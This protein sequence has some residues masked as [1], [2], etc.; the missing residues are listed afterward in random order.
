MSSSALKS[1]PLVEKMEEFM[2][3]NRPFYSF[4]FFPPKTQDGVANLFSRIER[5]SM[6]EPMFMDITWGAGGSTAQLTMD[7]SVNAQQ[8]CSTDVMMHLTCTEMTKEVVKDT[9]VKAKENGVRNILALRGDPPRGAE[10]WQ[11]CEGGFSHAVDLVRFI[12]QE[13]GDHFGIAVAGYP[14]G[15]IGAT[16]IDDDI[17]F[18]KEKVEAGADLVITQLFYDVDVFLEW[19]AKCRKAGITCPII[20]GIMPI[21]NYNGFKRMTSFCKTAVPQEIIE[22]LEPIK[23]D[24]ARVKAYG[25]DL[26]S[27]MCQKLLDNGVPGLHF[28]TL[29]LERSVTRIL[30]Q[31][32]FVTT[33]KSG[34]L[35]WKQSCVAR[36]AGE[37][38]RPIF[39]ANRPKSYLDRTATW[40]DFPNGRWGNAASPAYGELDDHHLLNARTGTL[41]ERAKMWGS[42]PTTPRDVYVVFANYIEQKVPRLPWC[43]TAV[44]L[45]T[46]PIKDCLR[47]MNMNG[48]LSI[49][50]QPRVNGAPSSDPAV[51]WGGPGGYIYQKAYLEFFASASN[52]EKL[53]T[54]CEKYPS[55]Q[56][57][58]VNVNGDMVT[59]TKFKGDEKKGSITAVTW[60]VFPGKEVQQP[61]VVD[62]ESF[63]V[64]KDEAFALWKVHW[65]SIY[66]AGTPSWDL[67]Q[68]IHDTFYLVNIVDNDYING[69]IFAFFDR[70]MLA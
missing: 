43:D 68:N 7:L 25:I 58:A 63:L 61:T 56:Y 41:A 36:R 18:L 37:D 52:L 26:G 42:N 13:F 59:N 57:T 47:R 10:Q 23:G 21:Q 22:A 45:E 64:W 15:H 1:S 14:E 51:G 9:L 20:P 17:N 69:D 24:D 46:V 67:L 53:C 50:S 8:I 66:Q 70:L 12:R 4:E 35:P 16:S 33:R 19:T 29:N 3:E 48:Y 34:A 44:Q 32:A 55:F 2:K 30:E 49:N 39:W 40:D 65:Q 5:M 11:P 6:L 54:H 31:L 62:T 60:G 38:V 28:Y 27:K